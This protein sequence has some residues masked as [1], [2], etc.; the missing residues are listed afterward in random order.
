MSSAPRANSD[1]RLD[2]LRE[3]AICDAAAD[4]GRRLLDVA[5][6]KF[7]RARLFETIDAAETLAQSYRQRALKLAEEW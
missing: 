4:Q 3:A 6:M 7:V 1:A 2:L 5:D